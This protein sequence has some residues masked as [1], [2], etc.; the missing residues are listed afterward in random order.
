[1]FAVWGA[2]AL[3][4]VDPYWAMVG[5]VPLMFGLGYGH[6]VDQGQPEGDEGVDRPRHQAVEGRLDQDLGRVHRPYG[7]SK[8]DTGQNTSAL[9]LNTQVQGGDVKVIAPEGSARGR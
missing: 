9:P 6:P 8:F 3:V 5:I 2:F 1:M 7:Q 4:H